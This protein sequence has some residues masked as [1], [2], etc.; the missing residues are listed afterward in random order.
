MVILTPYQSLI[1]NFGS[2]L[3]YQLGRVVLDA[4]TVMKKI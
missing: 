4:F 2:Y 1:P 3:S